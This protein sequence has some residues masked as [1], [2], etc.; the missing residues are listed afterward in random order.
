V[1]DRQK[2]LVE[3][4]SRLWPTIWAD[5]YNRNTLSSDTAQITNRRALAMASDLIEQAERDYSADA[6]LKP[7]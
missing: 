1:T 2:F 7:R 4:A 5:G 3:V 6:K